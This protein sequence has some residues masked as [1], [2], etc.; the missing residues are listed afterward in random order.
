[1]F[2]GDTEKAHALKA[3]SPFSTE[4]MREYLRMIVVRPKQKRSRTT[5]QNTMTL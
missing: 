2:T 5:A 4:L 1:M 3:R